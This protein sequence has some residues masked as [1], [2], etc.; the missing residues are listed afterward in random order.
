[1]K[2]CPVCS[3]DHR[4]FVEYFLSEKP[5]DIK[6]IS[7]FYDIPIQDLE[8]HM[9]YCMKRIDSVESN[10]GKAAHGSEMHDL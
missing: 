1:M 7:F 3:F 2:D 10:Q 4:R 5:F 9:T 8:Y 6:R